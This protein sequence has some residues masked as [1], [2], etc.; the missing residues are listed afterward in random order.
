MDALLAL[1]YAHAR[2]PGHVAKCGADIGRAFVTQDQ[3]KGG[4]YAKDFGSNVVRE[5]AVL[6]DPPPPEEED[7]TLGV[8]EDEAAEGDA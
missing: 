4:C 2:Q 1:F 3:P 5:Y 8:Q 7:P 6:L